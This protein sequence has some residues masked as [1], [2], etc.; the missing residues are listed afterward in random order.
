[1][2][3][4]AHSCSEMVLRIIKNYKA[5]Y[6]LSWFNPLLQGNSR[7]SNVFVIEDEQCYSGAEQRAWEVC[8]VK[9]GNVLV[10]LGW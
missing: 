3:K 9:G 8:Y 1:M 7:T 2:V 10:S 4:I 5:H 6:S